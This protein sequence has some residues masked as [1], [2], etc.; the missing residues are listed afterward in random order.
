MRIKEEKKIRSSVTALSQVKPRIKRLVTLVGNAAV[1]PLC[2]QVWMGTRSIDTIV[3][4]VDMKNFSKVSI[5][6]M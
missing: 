4:N 6:T 1:L 2:Q 3:I 5:D